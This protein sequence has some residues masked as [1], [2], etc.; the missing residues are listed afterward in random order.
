MPDKLSCDRDEL[1]SSDF[2]LVK[3]SVQNKRRKTSGNKDVYGNIS[4]R[5]IAI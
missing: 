5:Y 4:C 1:I 2:L 3:N